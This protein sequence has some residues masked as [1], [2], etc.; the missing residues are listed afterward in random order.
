M[1]MFIQ[2]VPDIEHLWIASWVIE[3]EGVGGVTRGMQNS[4]AADDMPM[5]NQFQF[6][7]WGTDVEKVA[8]TVF[9]NVGLIEKFG[10]VR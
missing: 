4:Y 6:V 9:G 3:Y 7:Y 1:L 2:S 8:K 10:R 5:R